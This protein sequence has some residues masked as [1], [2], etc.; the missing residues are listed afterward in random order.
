MTFSKKQIF[1]CC[2]I[3]IFP[4]ITAAAPIYLKCEISTVSKNDLGAE[5]DAVTGSK[6]EFSVKLDEATGK[7]THTSNG[8]TLTNSKQFNSEGFFSATSISYQN[9]FMLD[10]ESVVTEVYEI[11]R[12]NLNVTMSSQVR[13]PGLELKVLGKT[14]TCKI[15]KVKENKI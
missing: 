10:S 3:F 15:K 5:F 9:K 13:V 6:N 8:K 1:L 12:S 2:L 7:V 11:D 14:G 4:T